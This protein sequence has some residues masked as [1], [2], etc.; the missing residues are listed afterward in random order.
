MNSLVDVPQFCVVGLTDPV[1]WGE[2]NAE[3]DEETAPGLQGYRVRAVIAPRVIA[4]FLHCL[5][6]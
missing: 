3:R 6:P 2:A 1:L 5:T 4:L